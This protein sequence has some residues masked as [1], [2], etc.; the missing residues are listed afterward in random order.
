MLSNEI[1]VPYNNRAL[2]DMMLRTPLNKRLNDGLHKDIIHFMDER[3]ERLGIHVV[4]GNETKRR[5]MLERIYFIINN[6]LPF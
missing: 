6:A 1:T 5:E 3:I 2:M 4:N